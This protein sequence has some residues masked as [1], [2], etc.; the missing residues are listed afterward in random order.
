MAN[1]QQLSQ[2][3]LQQPGMPAIGKKQQPMPPLQNAKQRKFGK[4]PHHV[5]VRGNPFTQNK[6][7]KA[8][9]TTLYQQKSETEKK[10]EC[11][12][13]DKSC[14]EDHNE[15][16]QELETSMQDNAS[17]T[18]TNTT[19]E[20][21]PRQ[22]IFIKVQGEILPDSVLSPTRQASLTKQPASQ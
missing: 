22:Q 5:K 16:Q 12:P 18:N 7:I 1:Q 4:Q 10:S 3:Q 17:N 9:G 8:Q 20:K 21:S 2:L 19:S 11:A 14:Q 15:E 6:G 13:V